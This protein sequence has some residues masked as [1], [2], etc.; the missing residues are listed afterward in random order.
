MP[1]LVCYSLGLQLGRAGLGCP[2]VHSCLDSSEDLQVPGAGSAFGVPAPLLLGTPHT[3]HLQED[4]PPH[5][6]G[7][8]VLDTLTTTGP[9]EDKSEGQGTDIMGGWGGSRKYN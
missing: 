5:L 4:I 7:S 9:K 3:L 1:R 8:S 2:G 6:L